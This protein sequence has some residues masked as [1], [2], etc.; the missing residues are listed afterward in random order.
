MSSNIF[1]FRLTAEENDAN[2][3]GFLLI[4][5][6]FYFQN[7]SDDYLTKKQRR[8]Y[9]S[10]TM[11]PM[12]HDDLGKNRG[13]FHQIFSRKLFLSCVRVYWEVEGE[14]GGV[15]QVDHVGQELSQP[16]RLPHPQ[17]LLRVRGADLWCLDQLSRP[18]L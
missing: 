6:F 14:G 11:L 4:K 13:K 5:S 10:L 7:F 18:Y 3:T 1:Y 12:R 8:K 17:P 15:D 2:L 9:L 16:P